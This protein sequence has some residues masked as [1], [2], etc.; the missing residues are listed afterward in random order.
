MSSSSSSSSKNNPDH[1]PKDSAKE[2]SSSPG[3]LSTES[4]DEPLSIASESQQERSTPVSQA[5]GNKKQTR[6]STSRPA[7]DAQSEGSTS[8]E[9]EDNSLSKDASAPMSTISVDEIVSDDDSDSEKNESGDQDDIFV[10]EAKAVDVNKT[11]K[12]NDK[13]KGE[14]DNDSDDESIDFANY[15]S[16][17]V[18]TTVDDDKEDSS[19]ESE[20]S[21]DSDYSDDSDC[22][23]D[24]FDVAFGEDNHVGTMVLVMTIRKVAGFNNGAPFSKAIFQQIEIDLKGRSCYKQEDNVWKRARRADRVEYFQTCYDKEKLRFLS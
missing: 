16:A 22:Y 5:Q 3:S 15:C 10:E 9:T 2:D 13:S 20:G 23:P 17:A 7:E 4:K 1:G 18:G 11:K 24:N 14:D 19:V 6:K 12:K 8:N 21:A